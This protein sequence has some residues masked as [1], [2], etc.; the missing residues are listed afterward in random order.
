MA[1]FSATPGA[2]GAVSRTDPIAG[3]ASLYGVFLLPGAGAGEQLLVTGEHSAAADD[4]LDG[5]DDLAQQP[6]GS[7]GAPASVAST[8]ASTDAGSVV[9]ARDG[10]TLLWSTNGLLGVENGSTNPPIDE[11]LAYPNGAA[12]EFTT[13]AT[14]ATDSTGRLWLAWEGESSATS[15]RGIYLLQ[16]DPETGASLPAATPQLAPDSSAV[17]NAGTLAL[18]CNSICHV[19]YAPSGS[20][21][22]WCPGRPARPPR[23]PSSMTPRHGC[24]DRARGRCRRQR[25][26]MGRLRDGNRRPQRREDHARGRRRADQHQARGD[27]GAGGT[28]IVSPAA[29]A[30]AVAYDGWRWPPP[31]AW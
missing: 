5:L 14:L 10:R 22:R 27:N 25:A 6:D 30:G 15:S 7:F 20:T 9:L 4:P 28:A 13:D 11:N 8:G 19:V 18:A 12:L 23:S 21:A 3:W 29:V 2:P 1:R 26:A 16:L 31:T 24:R 17:S